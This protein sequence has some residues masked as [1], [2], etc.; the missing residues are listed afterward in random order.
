MAD[1][2][3]VFSIVGAIIAIGFSANA[4]FKKTGFPDTLL[5]I[6]VGIILGPLLGVVS[7]QDMLSITP[8]LTTLT[9]MMILFEGGLSMEISRVLSQSVRAIALAVLYVLTAMAFVSL[10]AYF[11]LGLG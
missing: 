7:R 11:V 2:L 4:L 9:L 5:L 6:L 3:T 1:V 8:F 10:F